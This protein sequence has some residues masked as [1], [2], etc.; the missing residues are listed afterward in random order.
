MPKELVKALRQDAKAKQFF[1]KLTPSRQKEIIR[2][3]GS[4]KTEEALSRN[5]KKLIAKYYRRYPIYNG[6]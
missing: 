3:L 2:Y 1:E 5:I 6:D 4:L